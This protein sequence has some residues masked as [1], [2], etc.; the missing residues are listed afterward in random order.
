MD[1]DLYP[2]MVTISPIKNDSGETTHFVSLQQDLSENEALENKF[3]QAQ[4]MEAL[5]TLV[6]GIAHEFNNALAGITGNLHL[7]KMRASHLPAVIEKLDAIEKLSFRSGELIKNLLS[8]ARKGVV[9]K[10]HVDFSLFLKQIIKLHSISLPENIGLDLDIETDPAIMTVN[11]DKTLLQQVVMNL[12]NNARDALKGA[13]NPLITIKLRKFSADCEFLDKHPE[14]ADAQFACLSI[15]DN[16]MG[17]NAVDLPHILEPFYTTKEVGKGTGLGLSMV[18]GAVQTHLGC[19]EVESTEGE[20]SVFRIF[21]PLVE[22]DALVSFSEQAE[23]AGA[24]MNETILLVD[25]ESHI[26]DTGKEVLEDLGYRVL[27]ASDGIEA[28]DIFK[29]N[30]DTISIVITDIMMPRLGGIEAVELMM[31][32]R[33]DM[34]AIFTTGYDKEEERMGKIHLGRTTI[35]HKPYQV[36]EF[37]RILRK[38]LDS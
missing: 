14:T 1:G 36:D 2:V 8:F 4:K 35:I 11:W 6:G 30:M 5:G 26:L 32:L 19:M 31:K 22:A 10:T 37:S 3:F 9:Q 25:D 18:I 16:G 17:I 34:K 20:G 13:D 12:I 28:V 24:G 21:L 7:A 33:P 15:R 29:A 23:I 27:V 38:V